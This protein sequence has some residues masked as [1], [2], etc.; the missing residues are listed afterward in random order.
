[1]MPHY[2]GLDPGQSGGVAVLD[3]TGK[4]VLK[5]PMPDL[6]KLC[7][8]LEGNWPTHVFLEQVASRPGQGVSSVFKFG[9]HYGSLMGVLTAL[10]LPHTLLRPQA[11]QKIA[12][13]GTSGTDPKDRAAQAAM[14]LWP[15]EDWLATPRCRKPH[16]G[17][18]DAALI[19]YAGMRL[20]A[21]NHDGKES[22]E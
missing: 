3:K 16:D 12:C 18:I 7:H 21:K 14:R 10:G 13:V 22:N 9:C 6:P 19:C 11:W 15:K 4:I 20:L 8:L 2:V 1:M 17:M 5:E